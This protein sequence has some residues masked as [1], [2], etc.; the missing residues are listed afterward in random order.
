MLLSDDQ[1]GIDTVDGKNPPSIPVLAVLVIARAALRLRGRRT[2]LV[3][4][5]HNF[6]YTI[7][8][9]SFTPTHPIVRLAK[10][11]V[12]RNRLG[13]KSRY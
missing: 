10:M 9:L 3:I 8:Q 5:W 11:Y 13:M 7:L 6:G 1:P 4:D 12:Q 2:R